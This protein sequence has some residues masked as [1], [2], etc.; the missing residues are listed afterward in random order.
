MSST[1]PGVSLPNHLPPPQNL[2]LTSNFTP[3][4]RPVDTYTVIRGAAT[5]AQRLTATALG[6]R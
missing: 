3:T 1:N 2:T 6:V 5:T 4:G